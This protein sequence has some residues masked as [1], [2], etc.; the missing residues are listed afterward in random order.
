MKPVLICGEDGLP[1]EFQFHLLAGQK[2]GFLMRT[3]IPTPQGALREAQASSP[4]ERLAKRMYLR[5][6]IGIAGESDSMFR[7]ELPRY[8]EQWPTLVIETAKQ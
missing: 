2:I 6:G 8:G 7:L 3:I 1:R 5:E 4:L